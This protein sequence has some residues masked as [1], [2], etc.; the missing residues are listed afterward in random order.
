MNKSTYNIKGISS[1]LLIPG[2]GALF[3]GHEV[4]VDDKSCG[5]GWSP[6]HRHPAKK[7]MKKYSVM[8]ELN[9]PGM[10]IFKLISHKKETFTTSLFSWHDA[11]TIW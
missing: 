11:Y 1:S 6:T 10:L 8:C 4:A 3:L 7:H 5:S 9:M 2:V